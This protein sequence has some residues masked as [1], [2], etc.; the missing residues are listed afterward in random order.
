MGH[1]ANIIEKRDEYECYSRDVLAERVSSG[2]FEV[3]DFKLAAFGVL[4]MYTGLAHWYS[5]DGELP[6]TDIALKFSDMALALVGAR[7]EDKVLRVRDLGLSGP[8]HFHAAEE[9]RGMGR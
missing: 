3:E 8:D 5:P 7:Q 9:R 6:I 4:D 1:R 2:V